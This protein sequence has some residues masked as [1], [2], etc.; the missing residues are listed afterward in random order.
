MKF[1]ILKRA[2]KNRRMSIFIENVTWSQTD[3]EI[4]IKLPIQ[5]KK[6]T[7]NVIITEKFMKINIQ[8]YYYELF[9]EG[10]ICPE[11]SLCKVLETCIKCILKK[12]NGERWES[13]GTPSKVNGKLNEKC[14]LNEIRKE[15][16]AEYEQKVKEQCVQKKKDRQQLERDVL[17][18][19][20]D[21]DSEIRAKI[22]NTQKLLKEQQLSGQT[23]GKVENT[24]PQ[25]NSKAAIQKESMKP[26]PKLPPVRSF[27]TIGVTFSERRFKTPKRESLEQAEREWCAK[28]H[29]IMTKNVGFCDESLNDDERDPKWLLNKGREF[30]EKK[31]FLGAISAFSSGIKIANESAD[32]YLSRAKAHFHLKNFQRCVSLFQIQKKNEAIT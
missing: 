27:A 8:P 32:L 9:F 31:N 10:T 12:S 2:K 16:R 22:E 18:R 15:R 11:E 7:D 3:S 28:Q 5:G 14:T 29:E 1:S 17:N 24:K 23:K 19:R 21:R 25:N 4:I 30:Y 26:A 13:L 20:L 6:V